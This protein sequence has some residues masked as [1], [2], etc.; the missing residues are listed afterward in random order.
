VQLSP[1]R[2]KTSS[3]LPR[4]TT[5]KPAK[6]S[7]RCTTL[8][9]Q[10]LLTHDTERSPLDHRFVAVDPTAGVSCMLE[11]SA[12]GRRLPAD[13][14]SRFT[15][16]E[17]VDDERCVRPG[18]AVE[19]AWS[20]IRIREPSANLERWSHSG[21]GSN[22]CGRRSWPVALLTPTPPCRT[23][24]HGWCSPPGP[25]PSMRAVPSSPWAM[26]S[27]RRSGV[28]RRTLATTMPLA[29][30]RGCDPGLPEPVGRG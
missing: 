24:S 22:W 8:E 29:P 11:L 19:I 9:E 3:S 12:D 13:A 16:G 10:H 18:R 2:R 6:S 27:L 25:V 26:L 14:R 17:D 15:T 21:P 5:K 20:F 1:G 30:A 23:A 28:V 7:Q 4:S